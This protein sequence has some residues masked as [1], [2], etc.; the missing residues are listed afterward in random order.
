MKVA[1]IQHDIVW[2]DRDATLA[3]LAPTVAQ[4]AATGADLVVLTEMF[5]TGFS[6]ATH[7]TA[8]AVD[9][10]TVAWMVEQARSHGVVLAGSVPLRSPTPEDSGPAALPTN[11]LLVV[12][13][14][15]IQ[16]RYDKVHPFAYAGE[17]ERFRAG[18]QR[19]STE[20]AGM[21][22][23]LSVCYDLR[24]ANLYWDREPPVD[25]EVV[26]ANWP[27]ARRRHW[28]RLIDA[29][30]IENQVYLVAVNRVG[31]G[32]GLAYAGDS[33]IVDPQ[34]EVLVAA[35]EVETILTAQLHADIVAEV[36]RTLP[37][38]PDRRVLGS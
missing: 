10:P 33:R 9:G 8:E 26:V 5:A 11:S 22:V 6:M 28:R 24:F 3:R 27:A 18:L 29:R 12:G 16:A 21:S 34:G 25:V 14:D 4:A 31:S 23:G 36:R 32:G 20:V 19:V 13:A 38:R 17:H 7:L 15:G 35:A 37:F 1:A 30:A 2:E